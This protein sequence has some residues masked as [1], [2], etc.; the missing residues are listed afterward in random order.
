MVWNKS[1]HCSATLTVSCKLLS[2]CFCHTFWVVSSDCTLWAPSCCFA[3][4]VP[5]PH[6]VSESKHNLNIIRAAQVHGDEIMQE[7]RL[8]KRLSALEE[9]M[10][11]TWGRI[12][13]L[14]QSTRSMLSFLGN[15]Q[16]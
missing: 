10:Q 12:E 6:T 4:P 1:L 8:R 2:V 7:P 13:D 16:A 14:L 5:C 15:L 9:G 11:Q 3:H